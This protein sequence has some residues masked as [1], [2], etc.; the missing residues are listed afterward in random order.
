MQD[1]EK[2]TVIFDVKLNSS[3]NLYLFIRSFINLIQGENDPNDTFKLGCDNV[4][5]TMEIFGGGNI[6]RSDQLV[7]V[8]GYQ[9]SPKEK[10]VKVDEIKEMC[11]FLSANKK[12]CSL[13]LKQLRDG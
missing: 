13:L 8:A 11:F 7:N 1:T 4:Y 6:L 5:E 2:I 9:A 10:Q 3:A 12:R